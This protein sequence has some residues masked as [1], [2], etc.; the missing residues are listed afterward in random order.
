MFFLV[1][2]HL[3]STGLRAI[4][5]LL[6]VVV[7]C[8]I[9][10]DSSMNCTECVSHWRRLSGTSRSERLSRT[11]KPA[12]TM[13]RRWFCVRSARTTSSRPNGYTNSIYLL[14]FCLI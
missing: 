14:T 11:W 12:Y 6:C 2:A 5:R 9:T 10:G 1:P 3:D 13:P 4:K 7:M 8:A